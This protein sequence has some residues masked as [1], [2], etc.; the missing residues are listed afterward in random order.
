M[1]KGINRKKKMIKFKHNKKRNSAFLY[2]VIIQEMTKAVIS[3]DSALQS[4]ITTLIKESFNPRSM[5][6]RELKLYHALTRTKSV[7]VLTAEKIIN[8]VKMRHKE[9]NKKQL[10]MEQNKLTRKIRKYF[11]ND[12]FSNFVPDYKNLASISQIFNHKVPINSKVLLENELIGKMSVKLEEQKMVP[13]DNLVYKSFVKNFNEEYSDKLLKEQKE[14]L[15]KF[16]T[17]F[18]DSLIELNVY[19]NDEISRLK[20]ELKKSLNIKEIQED[21]QMK[22]NASKVIEMLES[23]KNK[24]PDIQMVKEVIK[25]QSL[26][27]EL[28]ANVN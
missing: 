1:K 24:K 22:T 26:V 11:T 17:S 14:L 28:N 18:N 2:E 3:G 20:T 8:E 16:I 21:T 19:L 12:V 9:L 4:R 27:Q 23:Y 7:G 6:Y 13:I 10:V 5:L 25:V 15:T